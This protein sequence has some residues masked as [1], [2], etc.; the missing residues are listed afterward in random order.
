MLRDDARDKLYKMTSR[1]DVRNLKQNRQLYNVHDVCVVVCVGT[2]T[3]SVYYLQFVDIR[4][5]R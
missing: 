4:L 1:T 3:Y 5:Q 2:C